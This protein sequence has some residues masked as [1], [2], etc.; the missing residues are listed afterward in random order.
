MAEYPLS[1]MMAQGRITGRM[2]EMGTSRAMKKAENY[3]VDTLER[4]PGE[5]KVSMSNA[6]T[7]AGHGL[8][9]SEKR[10]VGGVSGNPR[11]FRRKTS[12]HLFSVIK[13]IRWG[14]PYIFF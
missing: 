4:L 14:L 7:R 13:S 8:N 5:R 6:L 1:A 9:L 12:T 11:K 2:A 3:D 10:L